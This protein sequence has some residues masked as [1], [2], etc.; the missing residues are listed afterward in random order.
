MYYLLL[1]FLLKMPLP[2]VASTL[3]SVDIAA[4]VVVDEIVILNSWT[5]TQ[6]GVLI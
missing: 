5:M 4:V 1:N 3:Q 6:T 2:V